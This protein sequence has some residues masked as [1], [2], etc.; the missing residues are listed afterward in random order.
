MLQNTICVLLFCCFFTL[1][2]YALEVPPEPVRKEQNTTFR[3]VTGTVTSVNGEPLAGASVQEKGTTNGVVTDF[4]GD[5][6]I[7]VSDNAV[8]VVSYIGFKALEVPVDG[9]EEINVSLQEDLAQLDEVVVVGYGTQRKQDLTGAV[10]VVKTDEMLQQPTA[11]VTNQLQGRVSGVTITGSGQPGEAPQIKIRGANTFGNN[12]PLFV[13]D[14]IPT[15]N[16]N[17]LN[18]ND[19]ES[20]QVL[21]DAGSASIYGSRA[22]NG[23][24]IITTKKGKGRVKVT[25]DGY[26]GMQ[27]VQRGNPWNILSPQEMA[28]LKWAALRNTNPGTAIDDPQYGNG[29]SPILPNYISPAGAE[30]VD[31]S[32]YFVNPFYTDSG[33]LADFYRIVK[34][35]KKGT[36]WFQE[37]FRPANIQSHN[38]SVS[39]GNENGNYLFSMNYFNQE[40]TLRETYLKRYTIR[41]NSSY[42][43]SDHIRVGENIAF[44]ITDNPQISALTEGSAIG[45]AFRQQPI[46]PVRDI[47]GNFAGSAGNDLGNAKNPVAIQERTRNNRGV[48]A[49]LFGSIFA[50]IDFLDHL[51][52]VRV[53]VG[54]IIAIVTTPL[55]SRNMKI[56][57]II[58]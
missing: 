36:N 19:I 54:N 51:H 28:D 15:D 32:R 25:Y 24:I 52:Y 42:N 21:K 16:I 48:A 53:M 14:G 39:S 50:E 8:L 35:N 47:M 57:R 55:L 2:G 10:S 33:E 34:A 1:P 31:E 23:V 22:A 12:S 17:D 29:A 41:V 38:V 11:Q 49:R 40:G 45:M 6:T 13:V 20:M 4:D 5:F 56:R 18:P 37:I 27:T 46:I 3:L 9:R 58:L 26:Y 30:T 7:E 43:I 44:S